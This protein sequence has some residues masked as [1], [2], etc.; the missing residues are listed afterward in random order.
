[1]TEAPVSS[2]PKCRVGID[3]GGTFTDLVLVDT[4]TGGLTFYK[5]PSRPAEPAEAVV[6][7]LAGIIDRAGVAP[8]DIGLLVHGTTLGLNTIIQRRGAK[9]ALVVSNGNRD[10]F[11]I[12]RSRM[13]SSYDLSVPKEE[14]L[15]PRDLVFEVSAR[16]LADGTVETTPRPEELS[17]LAAE[18]RRHEVDA[19]AIM[20]LNAYVDGSLEEEVGKALEAALPDVLIT[21]SA[22]LWPEIREY[23]RALVAALNAYIHP[24]VSRYLG[25]L[26]ER[27]DDMGVQP[28]REPLARG[29]TPSCPARPR[30][31]SPRRGSRAR[32]A[33]K[34]S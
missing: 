23:E 24:L 16:M 2:S 32:S 11:E 25:R 33:H 14:P 3:V 29:S 8:A 1:M 10:V 5:E 19:V 6:Q 4:D 13:P 18:L 7:G 30:A 12:G 20:F 34:R 27:L 26:R 22:R 21:H 31:S 17:Q 15:V 28:R 9:L